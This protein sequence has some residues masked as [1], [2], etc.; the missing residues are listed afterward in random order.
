MSI[1]KF[2]ELSKDFHNLI[3]TLTTSCHNYDICLSL[4]RNSMLQ[5]CLTCTKRSRDKARTTLYDRIECIERT[6]S[7]FE[8]LKW[9]RLLCIAR[10]GFLYGPFLNHCNRVLF[11]ILILKY[12]DFFISTIL[13]GRLKAYDFVLPLENKGNH[14]LVG[15]VVFIN[16][17]KPAT[18]LY[19]I[20]YLSERFVLPQFIF[21]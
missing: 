10:N 2:W 9:T 1:Y 17:T 3:C 7:G 14:Y 19:K 11:A 8:Q 6:Y 20:T 16:L 21:L 18:C 15:L 4:L 13:A 12:C 5:H